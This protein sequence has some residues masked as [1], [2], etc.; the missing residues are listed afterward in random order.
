MFFN[1]TKAYKIHKFLLNFS[2]NENSELN[3]MGFCCQE[4]RLPINL[5][6]F[7]CNILKRKFLDKIYVK[8][9]VG[10]TSFLASLAINSIEGFTHYH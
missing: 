1:V 8:S 6:I 3:P 9:I 10:Y 4:S 5:R 2:L 7:L